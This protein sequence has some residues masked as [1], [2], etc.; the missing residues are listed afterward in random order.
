MFKAH[1]VMEEHH[2]VWKSLSLWHLLKKWE[3]SLYH[4]GPKRY[5]VLKVKMGCVERDEMAGK[6]GIT[7]DQRMGSVVSC[8]HFPSH[9][10]YF[11]YFVWLASPCSFLPLISRHGL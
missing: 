9:S 7:S 10:V 8:G 6:S 5:S 11:L 4:F 3:V 1:P 2:E